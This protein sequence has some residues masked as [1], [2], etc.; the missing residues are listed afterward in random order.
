[1]PK[2]LLVKANAPETFPPKAKVFEE[3]EMEG[4]VV[5]AIAPVCCERFCVPVN[6][7]EEEME[8]GLEM[9]RAELIALMV[10]FPMMDQVPVPSAELLSMFRVPDEMEIPPENVLAPARVSPPLP[11]FKRDCDPEIKEEIEMLP[12]PPMLEGEPMVMAFEQGA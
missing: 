5:R 1:M 10:Q 7:N 12:V 6:V 2:P 9:V 8:M 11:T 4:E 3:T